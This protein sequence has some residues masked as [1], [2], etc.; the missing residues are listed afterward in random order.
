MRL[1]VEVRQEE[2]EYVIASGHGVM[3]EHYGERV[4]LR[5]GAEPVTRPIPP[6]E[7]LTRPRQP[8]G[9]EPMRWHERIAAAR[10]VSVPEPGA[11]TRL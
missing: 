11:E 5:P 8:P 1:R 7:R 6:G 10:G 3:I 9:R 2:V 4:E